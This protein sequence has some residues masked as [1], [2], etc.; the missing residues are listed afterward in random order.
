MRKFA[1]AGVALALLGLTTVTVKVRIARQPET[2][3]AMRGKRLAES[4][5]CFACHGPEGSGGIADPLAPGGTVPDWRFT[6]LA[7][8]V[9][10]EQDVREWIL[11]GLPRC[12]AERSASAQYRP[13]VPMP[14]YEHDVTASQLE[15]LVAYVLA[16]SGWRAA[17]P[18]QAYEGR[19]LAVRL[20]CFGCHGPSGMGGV[21]NPGSFKG[22]IPPWTGHEFAELVRDEA[23]LR[24]WIL[25]GRIARLW[26][27]STAR[28]FL[29][30]QKISMPAYHDQLA[31]GELDQLVAF[32]QWLREAG[33]RPDEEPRK[34]ATVIAHVRP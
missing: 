31:D 7:M 22:H 17:I 25:E 4:L 26:N 23:E 14:S 24:E 20:G 10:S 13:L 11:Y 21:A 5:G 16:V 6:T 32:I 33:V 3:P 8:F 2:T 12:Q 19:K 9:K 27:S 29:N 30:R 18:D 15:D 28:F 34:A 1:Y